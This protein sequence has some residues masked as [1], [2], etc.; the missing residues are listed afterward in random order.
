MPARNSAQRST[1]AMPSQRQLRVGELV[2]HKL[3]QMLARGEVHD[4]V[5][6]AH[7]V[8]IPEVRMSPDLKIATVYVMPLGGGD[9]DEVLVALNAN[10]KYI[11]GEVARAVALKFAPDMRF[12]ADDT[13]DEAMRIDA[14]LN[15]P[16]VRQDIKSS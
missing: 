2:R 8:S 3:S 12:R 11:R 7:V 5:L 10:R 9:V 1:G 4:D 14:L 16:K 15:S 13:F 6:S